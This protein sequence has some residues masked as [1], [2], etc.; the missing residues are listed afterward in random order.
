MAAVIEPT[1]RVHESGLS[2]AGPGLWYGLDAPDGDAGAWALAP[3]GSR[4]YRK[5]GEGGIWYQKV[6]SKGLDGDWRPTDGAIVQT[7]TFSQFTDGGAAAGTLDLTYQI[8]IGA[9]VKRSFVQALTGFTGNSS[10][11]LI[12]GDGTDHDRYNTGTPSIF[13]TA[14]GETDL[15]AVSGTAYHTAAATVRLTATGGSDWGAVTA[16]QATI[17]IVIG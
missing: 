16:G 8:P 7:V 1:L 5:M 4:Y 12:I 17:V 13:T 9:T 3:V 11:T 10:C 15:G 6:S 14:A 2:G